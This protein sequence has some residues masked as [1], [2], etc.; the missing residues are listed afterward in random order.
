M[1]P[2]DPNGLKAV[3]PEELRMAMGLDADQ[4][5]ELEVNTLRICAQFADISS[6]LGIGE[7]PTEMEIAFR[8]SVNS[9]DQYFAVL[10]NMMIDPD[11]RGMRCE[12]AGF[13]PM[14]RKEYIDYCTE[15]YGEAPVDLAGD[16]EMN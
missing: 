6:S 7:E 2:I 10:Y 9:K 14:S 5:E 13:K 8:P 1:K 3:L 4:F 11:T 15:E 12:V 16:P